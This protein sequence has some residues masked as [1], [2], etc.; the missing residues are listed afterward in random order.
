MQCDKKTKTFMPQFLGCPKYLFHNP[1]GCPKKWVKNKTYN[2]V[3]S[4]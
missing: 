3:V 4:L 2:S 1:W